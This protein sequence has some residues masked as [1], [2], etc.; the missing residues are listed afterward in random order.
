[1]ALFEFKIK[2]AIIQDPFIFMNL[3]LNK[4]FSQILI[5]MFTHT[6]RAV[7]FRISAEGVKFMYAKL[8]PPELSSRSQIYSRIRYI[9]VLYCGTEGIIFEA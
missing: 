5:P 7:N 2:L 8:N 3:F 9:C 6:I 4:C 1:M